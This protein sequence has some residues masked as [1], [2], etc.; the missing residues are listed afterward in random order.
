MTV[1]VVLT[2]DFEYHVIHNVRNIE[3]RKDGLLIHTNQWTFGYWANDH[4]VIKVYFE[5]PGNPNFKRYER[6]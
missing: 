6:N 4:E 5:A 3:Y 2:M 1:Y